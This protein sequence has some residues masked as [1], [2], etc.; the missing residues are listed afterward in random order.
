MDIDSLTRRV[1]TILPRQQ[2]T[3]TSKSVSEET[4]CAK[5]ASL[6]LRFRILG[7]VDQSGVVQLD[8]CSDLDKPLAKANYSKISNIMR[9]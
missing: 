8:R 4:G 7:E 9:M 1:M 6:T 2:K 3:A 5:F